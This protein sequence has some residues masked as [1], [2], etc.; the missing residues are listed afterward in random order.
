MNELV[1]EGRPRTTFPFFSKN[2]RHQEEVLWFTLSMLSEASRS[3]WTFPLP[4]SLK[5]RR[6][7]LQIRLSRRRFDRPPHGA[8][9][10]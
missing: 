3:Y 5:R 2:G 10:K 7:H 1:V 6:P 8:K 9:L 4:I